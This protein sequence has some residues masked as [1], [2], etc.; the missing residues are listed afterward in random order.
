[1]LGTSP[2]FPFM[3]LGCILGLIF[4][5]DGW[6]ANPNPESLGL[7]QSPKF[8]GIVYIISGVVPSAIQEL[9]AAIGFDD[10]DRKGAITSYL[11]GCTVTIILLLII[12]LAVSFIYAKDLE[13]ERGFSKAII[14][15]LITVQDGFGQ[16]LKVINFLEKVEEQK[17]EALRFFTSYSS[18]L[19]SIL[20]RGS[21]PSTEKFIEFLKSSLDS[22]RR[23]L[24]LP[25]KRFRVCILFLDRSSEQFFYIAGSA[26]RDAPFSRKP[27][28]RTGSLAGVVILDPLKP[29]LNVI[30]PMPPRAEP[31]LEPPDEGIGIKFEFYRRPES[32]SWYKSVVACGIG[33]LTDVPSTNSDFP[34]MALCVD[35]RFN[36]KEE[37]MH[38]HIDLCVRFFAISIAEAFLTLKISEEKISTWLSE[39][40]KNNSV[41]PIN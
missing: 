17:T 34:A 19:T 33:P 31:D 8:R 6:R 23:H 40:R 32:T 14:L 38:Q 20:V 29:V 18:K 27:L 41:E 21:E 2:Q 28:P 22:F 37:N 36:L 35:S 13:S 15:S 11:L 3:L 7:W 9:I 24:L 26:P 16:F 30:G 39:T 5:A 10:S 12:L 1:V 25:E 4:V